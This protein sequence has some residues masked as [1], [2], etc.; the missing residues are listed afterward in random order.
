[1]SLSSKHTPTHYNT[2]SSL[3]I[4]LLILLD[5]RNFLFGYLNTNN[6]RN[7]VLDLREIVRHVQFGY[8]V[9]SET[10]LDHNSF[11]STQF[12]PAD[13]DI[14]TRRGSD[15]NGGGIIEYVRID[16]ICKR[17]K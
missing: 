6:L 13:Y 15:G 8:F 12:K 7:T 10:K 2:L 14:R 17:L 16:V 11:P 5:P 9:I 3:D 4:D 1:M